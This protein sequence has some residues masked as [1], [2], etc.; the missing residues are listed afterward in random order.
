M[1]AA[2][3]S[4]ITTTAISTVL[5]ATIVPLKSVI[6]ISSIAVGALVIGPIPSGTLQCHR[7]IAVAGGRHFSRM[8]GAHSEAAIVTGR[9]VE[10][11][12]RLRWRPAEWLRPLHLPVV[13]LMAQNEL[14]EVSR[15]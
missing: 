9:T 15:E 2:T 6:P 10:S 12:L 8:M 4:G 5:A 3:G 11:G 1:I 13:L 7:L 14:R